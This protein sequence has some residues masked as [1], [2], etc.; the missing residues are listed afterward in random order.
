M[1]HYILYNTTTGF[2]VTQLTLS[3]AG[4]TKNLATNTH[5][6]GL[7]GKVDNVNNYKIDVT[8]TPHSIISKPADTVNIAE[9]IRQ[10]RTSILKWCDWTQAPDSPLSDSKK[11][12]WQ[13]YRQ[14]LRDLPSTNT[15]T[16][17]DDIT[18]PSEPS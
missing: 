10:K 12:E 3:D 8:T 7:E 4:L 2:I 5:M 15:A 17:V 11:T 18:W 14:A 9:Y 16:E 1:K 6:S 13:T